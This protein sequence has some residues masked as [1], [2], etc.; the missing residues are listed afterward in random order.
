MTAETVKVKMLADDKGAPEG[1]T[2][3]F[4][5]KDEEVD[6]PEFLAKYFEENKTAKRIGGKS[7]KKAE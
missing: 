7:A 5:R 2:V 4:Y 6:V 1:H 3:V